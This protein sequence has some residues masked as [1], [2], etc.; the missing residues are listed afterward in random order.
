MTK[1]VLAIL[2]G[3]VMSASLL[4]ACG[5]DKGSSSGV[6]EF[7]AF[8]DRQGIELTADNEIKK[9]IAD[10]IGAQCKETWLTGQTAEEAV[11]MYIASG[12]Y[13]DFMKLESSVT[14][15]RCCSCY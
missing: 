2:L 9:I 3:I 10:K 6:K 15:S 7:T 13:P 14:G 5:K 1:R 4:A 8:F 12:E 11:G